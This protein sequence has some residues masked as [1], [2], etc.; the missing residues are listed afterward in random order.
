L[1]AWPEAQAGRLLGEGASIQAV[2][3]VIAGPA[4]VRADGSHAP[5]GAMLLVLGLGG[6]AA[7]EGSP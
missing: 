5:S 4:M 7:L 2:A 3:P 6:V 1:L